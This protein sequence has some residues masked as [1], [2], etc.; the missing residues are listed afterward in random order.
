MGA[1]EV[2]QVTLRSALGCFPTGVAAV[3]ARNGSGEPVGLA[4]N[5]FTSVSLEPPL[6][7]FCIATTS[8]TWV[9]L[10]QSPTFAISILA[11]HHEPVC[12]QLSM[13]GVD[14]FADLE[15]GDAPS[16]SPIIGGAVAWFDCTTA[17]RHL[18]GDHEIVV[19]EVTTFGTS[20][21]G[22]QPLVF[23]RSKFGL[24]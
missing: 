22:L 19:G 18:A 11:A 23:H 5:S 9:Q 20:D 16:G 13:K 17:Q 12:R 1:V 2:D 8:S 4:A 10:Q 7:L 6:V 15:W 21:E 14:R 3:C 24:S